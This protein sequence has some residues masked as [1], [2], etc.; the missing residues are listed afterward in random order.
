[1]NLRQIEAWGAGIDFE[2]SFWTNFFATKGL[3]W[4]D[5]YAAR[6]DLNTPI[7]PFYIQH[8]RTDDFSIAKILDVGSGPISRLG[9]VHNGTRLDITACDPL[10]DHYAQILAKYDI[11]PPIRTVKAFAEDL[12]AYFG[13]NI[14]DLVVCTNALDHSFE[15]LRGIAQM[16]DV[17]KVGGTVLLEHL[18]N[19]AEAET[20]MG[21]HQWN[22]DLQDGHFIMWNRDARINASEYFS[23]FADVLVENRGYATVYFKKRAPVTDLAL[24]DER[25]RIRTLLD[26]MMAIS[27]VE[28]RHVA[29][30]GQ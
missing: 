3:Q 22:F 21:F 20:Y 26:A 14:F 11:T 15:P 1:M 16:L 12:S 24:T 4:P 23:Q 27:Y 17:V 18:F 5:D 19:E 9:K 29:T 2:I 25:T 7:Y 30:S 8:L 6:L 28:A 13:K 10:A